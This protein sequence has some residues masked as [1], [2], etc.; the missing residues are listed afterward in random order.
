VYQVTLTEVEERCGLIFPDVL[1]GADS[2][3]RRLKSIR[4]VVSERKPLTSLKD[5][6]WS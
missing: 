4:E 6:D 1:K 3:G 5:I 2:L